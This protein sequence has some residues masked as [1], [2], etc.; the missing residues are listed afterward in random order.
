[1]VEITV[2]KQIKEKYES[3]YL[4]EGNPLIKF[5]IWESLGWQGVRAIMDA[6][7]TVKY[8]HC[9]SIRFWKVA[10]EDE[11]VRAICQYLKIAHNCQLLELL[12]NGMTSLGC[13]FI[14]KILMREQNS[15]I[16]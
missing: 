2:C 4:E 3:E 7:K 10:C 11:G 16:Q 12:D 6:L 9:R 15:S 5:H 13:E 14:S 8:Q 1:L